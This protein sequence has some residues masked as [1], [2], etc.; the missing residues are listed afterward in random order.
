MAS[1]SES[2]MVVLAKDDVAKFASKDDLAKLATKRDVEGV[3]VRTDLEKLATKKDV[4]EMVSRSD[5]DKLAWKKDVADQATRKEVEALAVQMDDAREQLLEE[6][7]VSA[8]Q[9]RVDFDQLWAFVSNPPADLS[10]PLLEELL[11]VSRPKPVQRIWWVWLRWPAVAVLTGVLGYGAGWW[12]H[13]PTAYQRTWARLGERI[14]PVLVEQYAGLSK[15]AQQAVQEL[16]KTLRLTA[17][18]ERRSK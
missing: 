6:V 13:R 9:A 4:V 12:L 14:D 18:G 5:L 8:K 16:Y 3:V 10:L 7:K 15:G 1:I 17:P 11:A 2:E